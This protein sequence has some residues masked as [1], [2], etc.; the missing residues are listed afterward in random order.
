MPTEKKLLL[1]ILTE[2][3]LEDT[4]IDEITALGARGY[5]ISE[6]RGRGTHG[7]RSG[8]WTV[9]ANLRI[10]VV[11]EPAECTRIAEHLQAAYGRDYGLLMFT[12][13]IEL[14]I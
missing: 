13:P 2:A 3:V 1:T 10:E 11:G 4:V 5:T 6:A 14:Q 9:G 7:V 12:T 8:K